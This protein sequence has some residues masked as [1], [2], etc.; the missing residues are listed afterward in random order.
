MKPGRGRLRRAVAGAALAL[1]PSIGPSCISNSSPPSVWPPDDFRLI[2]SGVTRARGGE[3]VEQ[4]FRLLADGLAVYREARRAVPGTPLDLPV[5]TRVAAYRLRPESV[6]ACGRQL[7]RAG[8]FDRVLGQSINR[9]QDGQHVALSWRAFG[10]EGQVSSY[11]DN[12][13][14][15]DRIVHVVNSFL[16][17][18]HAFRFEA[19]SGEPE[20]KRLVRVPEPLDS[21]AGALLCHRRFVET[22]PDEPALQLD[23]FALAWAEGD[24]DTARGAFESL[25]RLGPVAPGD[26]L[27][28][29]IEWEESCLRP[30]EELIG[31]M[32][33]PSQ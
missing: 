27:V 11:V 30:L 1:L 8:L 16:P 32:S 3:R 7:E 10:G 25:T 4:R 26:D 20:P 13:G 33:E 17:E 5:F 23:L 24:V 31:T 19:L 28:E 22:W 2:V 15:L 12:G 6:R 29:M 14:S 21:G 18:G 9:E